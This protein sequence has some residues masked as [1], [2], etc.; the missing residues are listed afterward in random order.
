MTRKQQEERDRKIRAFRALGCTEEEIKSALEWDDK[1]DKGEKTVGVLSKEGRQVEKEMKRA[2]RK[3]TNYEF[4][5]RERKPD[6][7]KRELIARFDK[8]LNDVADEGTVNVTNIEREIEFKMDG[9]RYKIVLS[10]PHKETKSESGGEG[11]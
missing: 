1:I 5:K 7:A 3:M 11:A 9:R 10:A 6:E 4:S 2:E 8:L